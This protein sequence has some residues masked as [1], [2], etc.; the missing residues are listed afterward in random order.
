MKNRDLL[1]CWGKDMWSKTTMDDL[2]E[3][4][5]FSEKSRKIIE[6][7]L[8]KDGSYWYN[9]GGFYFSLSDVCFTII[10]PAFENGK[11]IPKD[12]GRIVWY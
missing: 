7:C 4:N 5:D 9:S 10:D 11:F 1:L 2:C 6:D 8:D 12:E 3:N